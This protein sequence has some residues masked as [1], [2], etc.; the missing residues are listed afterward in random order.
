[1]NR[2]IV[3]LAIAGFM[4][5]GTES[6]AD[7]AMG[8]GTMTEKHQMMK[9]CMAKQKAANSGMSKSDMRK[10]CKDQMKDQM[11]GETKDEMKE[12]PKD[13]MDNSSGMSRAPPQ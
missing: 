8:H 6:F 5:A 7:D 13:P 10:A 4:I 1:M 12:P 3:S 2:V 9:D 11:K